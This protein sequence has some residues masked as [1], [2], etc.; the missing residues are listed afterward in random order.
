MPF[1][2]LQGPLTTT[3]LRL[4]KLLRL[5]TSS[6][7]FAMASSVNART[8]TIS[9]N[10]FEIILRR[11]ALNETCVSASVSVTIPV[12]TIGLDEY[13]NQLEQIRQFENLKQNLV[14]GGL[15]YETIAVL[16]NNVTSEEVTEDN[17]EGRQFGNNLQ[18]NQVNQ[19]ESSHPRSGTKKYAYG[20]KTWGGGNYQKENQDN[21]YHNHGYD[22]FACAPEAPADE[23]F[24]NDHANGNENL[25]PRQQISTYQKPRFQRDAKRSLVFSRLHEETTHADVIDIVRGGMLLDVFMRNDHSCIVSFLEEEDAK[26]F[27]GYAKRKDLVILGRRIE[28][29]WA[30]RH[31]FLPNHVA[32]QILYGATRNLIIRN[33]RQ[34]LTEESIRGHSGG[35]TERSYAGEC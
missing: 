30:D 16:T 35:L 33:A 28:I 21:T 12:V 1:Y 19:S 20:T 29:N 3:F 6:S 4:S 14:N 32:K 18:N 11:A 25:Q 31:F 7:S 2:V 26:A 9:R 22:A 27:Y 17:S 15:P 23:F 8:V 34:R 10:Y 24:D 13:K 5:H